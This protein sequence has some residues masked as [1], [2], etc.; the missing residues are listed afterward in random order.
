MSSSV[1]VPVELDDR[2]EAP[3]LWGTTA[4]IADEMV[5]L[6]KDVL[7]VELGVR[8]LQAEMEWVRAEMRGVKDTE[9]A[10]SKISKI[11]V[12]VMK[13]LQAITPELEEVKG[14]LGLV[15]DEVADVQRERKRAKHGHE[16]PQIGG[17]AA[18]DPSMDNLLKMLHGNTLASGSR[19]SL[20]TSRRLTLEGTS[21]ASNESADQDLTTRLLKELA[22]G[23]SR[24][25]Q[26]VCSG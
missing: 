23:R 8:P 7:A 26:V 25:S 22:S 24:T 17:R 13:R 9:E 3:T 12:L 20:P 2:F 11:I 14:R 15:E 18:E 10:A 16:E 19:E 4:F 1:G 21:A 5:R 6:S